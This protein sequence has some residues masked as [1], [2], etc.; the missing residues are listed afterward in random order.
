MKI[1]ITGASGFIGSHITENL[2]E[3]GHKVY[4][5]CRNKTNFDKCD[6]FKNKVTWINQDHPE[7]ER[8]L[9]GIELDQFIH[10]AWAGVTSAERDDWDL[11]LTN[12]EFSKSMIDLAIRL[13]ARKLICLGSQAEYGLYNYKVTEEHVPEPTDAYGAVKLL[14]LYYL[15]NTAT[16]NNRIWYW[17][18]IFSIIG[19]NE[20]KSW[21]LSQVMGKLLAGEE[22]EL[23][24]GEQFYDYLYIV[25]F[26]N[27]L[28]QII[29]C[30]SDLSA[31]Y[32]ICS[33]RPV[34]IRNLLLLVAEKLNINGT[35]LKFGA[36]P[37]RKNQN[38]YMVGSPEKFESIFGQQ[39]LSKLDEV[40]VKI[41]NSYKRT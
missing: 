17:L 26:I 5:I 25:D 9:E 6:Q 35:N 28:T 39:E 34:K 40:I 38:M 18:R 41:T 36:I 14:T 4:A 27:A 21:L 29:T 15:Q 32:N 1:L 30:K 19:E 33:G 10:T 16:K 3:E 22:I 2:V 20:N 31:V 11:Q 23:T 8:K 12:F 7:W 13:N 24:Q 37:Y